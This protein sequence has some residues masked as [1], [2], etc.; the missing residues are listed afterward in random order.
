[1]QTQPQI[2][3]ALRESTSFVGNEASRL[4]I[5]LDDVLCPEPTHVTGCSPKD[6]P[7][8]V[9]ATEKD[10]LVI[11]HLPLVDFVVWRIRERLPSHISVQD[12][13]SAGHHGT[14]R[15]CEQV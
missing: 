14:C 13:R 7:G 15:R 5:V 2:E 10:R 11:E 6:K 8:S 12:L 9:A 1:M 3:A 4:H